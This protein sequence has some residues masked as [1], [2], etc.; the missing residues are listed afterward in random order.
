M[1]KERKKISLKTKE[2]SESITK[3]TENAKKEVYSLTQKALEDENIKKLKEEYYK[4]IDRADEIK[5][6]IVT[7][8]EQKVDKEENGK[9][10]RI[11]G[12]KIWRIMAY[13]AIYSFLGFCLES[14]YGLLT[15]G[16]IESRQSFLY[17]PFCGI[18]G[19]GAVIMILLLQ[20]FKKNNYTL[21]FGGYIIGS[22]IE[23]FV[24]LFGEMI[25]HVKWWDYSKEPFNING[26]VCLFY[27]IA[28]GLLAIYLVAHINP[29]IDSLIDRIKK[30]LPKYLLPVIFDISTVFLL[31]DCIIS[32]I[33]MNVFYSRLVYNYNLN[34]PNSAIYEKNYENILKNEKWSKFTENHF[35]DKKMLK[36]YPNLKMEDV[37]GNIIFVK[38][39]LGD[40]QPYYIKLFTPNENGVHLTNVE[41]VD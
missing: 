6:E 16:V 38:D 25:L 23:Y 28:W 7:K 17:G 40:I 8:L 41:K 27:S 37:D 10:I 31:S 39:V 33:A 2:I 35:S 18:Y 1:K 34:I 21:F 19:L 24:S 12:V 15:K 20:F 32:G 29:A 14:I 26:R 5:E 30:K 9:G 3:K 36:T 22:L 11:L 4:T 13:F